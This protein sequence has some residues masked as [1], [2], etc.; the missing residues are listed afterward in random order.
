MEKH[1][2][3][4]QEAER[5]GSGLFEAFGVADDPRVI[6]VQRRVNLD[7]DLDALFFGIGRG[8]NE[9]FGRDRDERT[10]VLHAEPR[11][12]IDVTPHAGDLLLEGHL[13]ALVALVIEHEIVADGH[14]IVLGDEAVPIGDLGRIDG[15]FGPAPEG[16]LAD[17]L[18]PACTHF[19][20]GAD[21]VL[22]AHLAL[23]SL[24]LK[25]VEAYA[26]LDRHVAVSLEATAKALPCL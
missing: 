4:R 26:A 16:L 23:E 24:V 18:D 9:H 13:P 6:E 10:Q 19:G 15:L 17:H 20:A 2:H 22:K 25:A 7:E 21:A 12:E 5:V 14:A 3:V 11:A 1:A 8:G